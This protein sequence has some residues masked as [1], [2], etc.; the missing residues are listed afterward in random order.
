MLL[1]IYVPPLVHL[2]HTRARRSR[3]C[4]SRPL[5]TLKR[6]RRGLVS[7]AVEDRGAGIE[8]TSSVANWLWLQSKTSPKDVW[9]ALHLGETAATRLDDNPKFWQ[10]L[11]YV[12]MF[13]AKKGNHWFSDG[14]VFEIL[15]KT[16]PQADLAV[17]FQ[18]LRAVP[19]MKNAA[20]ILQQYLF[21]SASSAT[22]RWMNEVWLQAG[23][24][25]QNVYTILRLSETP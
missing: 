12:N 24:S 2:G 8:D 4:C 21:A 19:G 17:I 5:T 22:R 10:W 13:R 15:A 7:P 11:E 6:V 18:A 23:E 9:N 3:E 25:P 14:D 16:T 20:T 1:P